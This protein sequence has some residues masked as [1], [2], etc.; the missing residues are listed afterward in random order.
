MESSHILHSAKILNRL[1]VVVSNE[2]WIRSLIIFVYLVSSVV[3]ISV[4]N[5]QLNTS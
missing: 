2:M 4:T 5:I 1:S 3:E